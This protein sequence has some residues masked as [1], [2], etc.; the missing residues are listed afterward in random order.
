VNGVNSSFDECLRDTADGTTVETQ[1]SRLGGVV[2]N[3]GLT[4]A[5]LHHAASLARECA[6]DPRGDFVPQAL[7]EALV[8]L[9]PCFDASYASCDC[10]RWLNVG[11]QDV[12]DPNETNPVAPEDD[13]DGHIMRILRTERSRAHLYRS[14]TEVCM[15]VVRTFDFYSEVDW[16]S[17]AVYAETYRPLGEWNHIIVPLGARK[18]GRRL[19]ILMR[20][21]DEGTFNDRDRDLLTLLQPHLAK[22][23]DDRQRER[24]VVPLTDRHVEVLQLLAAGLSTTEVAEQLFV[25]PTTVR[26][27]IENIFARLGVSNRA[28]A[29]ARALEMAN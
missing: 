25:S 13:S 15:D 8:E 9:I 20:S 18:G 29:V 24:D 5:E 17:S 2:T 12:A 19:I 28:A 14:P 26:K 11:F 4:A 21:K 27:H 22:L 10:V 16:R 6:D 3:R 7:L 23:A 1:R